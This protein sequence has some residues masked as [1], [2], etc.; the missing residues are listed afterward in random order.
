MQTRRTV[1]VGAMLIAILL[2]ATTVR[3]QAPATGSVWEYSSV[4]RYPVPT[5]WNGGNATCTA[6]ICYATPQ[7]CR[8]EDVTTRVSDSLGGQAIMTAAAKL[9]E[10][11]WELSGS[12]QDSSNSERVMYFRRLKVDPK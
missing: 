9:G 2:I 5:N 10:Q 4:T 11:G 12:T 7:G 3:S 8:I 1:Q 6:R